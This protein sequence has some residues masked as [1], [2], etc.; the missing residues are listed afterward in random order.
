MTGIEYPTITVDD[1]T[2]VVRPSN[3][4]FFLMRRRGL[5][6]SDPKILNPNKFRDRETN[7]VV[8]NPNGTLLWINNS[9]VYFSGCVA[10]NYIDMS[11]PNR[12]DLD[13]A[14]TADYWA[15]KLPDFNE[16]HR[17]CLEALGKYVEEQST[18]LAIVPPKSVAS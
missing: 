14:P 3:A 9:Y 18:K 7:V 13:A 15:V 17:L 4:A 6:L 12:V 5:D 11:R 8:D 10:E 2:I 16:V 1:K